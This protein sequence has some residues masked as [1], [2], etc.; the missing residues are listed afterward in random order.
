M[1]LVKVCLL[2]KIA[3]ER[4]FLDVS[5]Q[6]SVLHD[7]SPPP[8]IATDQ[9]QESRTVSFRVTFSSLSVTAIMCSFLL[10]EVRD[11]L[12]SDLFGSFD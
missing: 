7:H 8:P 10:F 11:K 6:L 5:R 12:P 3:E 2:V 9:E 4:R 1:K